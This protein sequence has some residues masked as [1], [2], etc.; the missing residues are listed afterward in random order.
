MPEL[1]DV[2]AFKQYMD[3]TRLDKTTEKVEVKSP[4]RAQ[5][6]L[7]QRNNPCFI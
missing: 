5:A 7:N 6:L 4:E 1:S 3:A 2:E